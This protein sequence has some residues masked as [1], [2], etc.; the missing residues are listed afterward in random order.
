MHSDD[1]VGLVA[2]VMIFGL[3]MVGM[4]LKH[5][6]KMAEMFQTQAQLA[7]NPEVQAL[8]EE[9]WELRTLVHEQTIALDNLSRPIPTDGRIQDRVGI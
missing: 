8:R 4:L 5:Q 2:I 3:P 7:P 6:R 9:V 1:I